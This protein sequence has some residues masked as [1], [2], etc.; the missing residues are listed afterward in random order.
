MLKMIGACYVNFLR[1]FKG[2]RI[3]S[4]YG[5]VITSLA[6]DTGEYASLYASYSLF[7]DLPRTLGWRLQDNLPIIKATSHKVNIKKKKKTEKTRR[8]KV[9]YK[10]INAEARQQVVTR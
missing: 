2:L 5:A 3:D 10:Y 8:F 1:F 4:S 6:L 9:V 7:K